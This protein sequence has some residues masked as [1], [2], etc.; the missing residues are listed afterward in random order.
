MLSNT[1]KKSPRFVFDKANYQLFLLSIAIVVIGFLLMMG[2]EDIYSFTKLT[3][4]P[5][6]IVLGFA[7]GF[8]A[9]LYKP[10]NS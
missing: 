7:V 3:V 8:I 1:D 4:A 5:I 6:V 9:I 10:K 2:Q